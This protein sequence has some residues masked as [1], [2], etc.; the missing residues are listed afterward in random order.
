MAE[1]V[2]LKNGRIVR[3]SN[4]T[5]GTLKFFNTGYLKSFEYQGNIYHATEGKES[6]KY[7]GYRVLNQVLRFYAD[8]GVS[9][10]EFNR[11]RFLDADFIDAIPQQK[12]NNGSIITEGDT[13]IY[14]RRKLGLAFDK[15]ICFGLF[16]APYIV[17][18]VL[19]FFGEKPIAI[20]D[21]VADQAL[22][23]DRIPSN[24]VAYKFYSDFFGIPENRVP[25]ELRADIAQYI[26]NI[27]TYIYKEFL[28]GYNNEPSVWEVITLI[29]LF[30]NY[31]KDFENYDAYIKSANRE[32]LNNLYNELKKYYNSF[33]IKLIQIKE[34]SILSKRISLAMGMP[35]NALIPVTVEEK[36]E[37]LD[38]LV[39]NNFL[40]EIFLREEAEQLV[41]KVIRSFDNPVSNDIN[42]FL[43]QLISKKYLDGQKQITLFERLYESMSTNW[44]ITELGKNIS[45]R[46]FDTDWQVDNTKGAL[47]KYLYQLWI[48][49]Q[50]NPYDYLTGAFK[51]D[52]IG[53]IRRDTNDQIAYELEGIEHVDANGQI[54]T[55]ATPDPSKQFYYT[56]YVAYDPEIVYHPKA[57]NIE[58]AFVDIGNSLKK[59]AA[60]IRICYKS[61]K[62][63]FGV[64]RDNHD[65]NFDGEHIK[66]YQDKHLK[67]ANGAERKEA[68]V[69]YGTYKIYQ[70]ISLFDTDQETKIPI[71]T[72]D[73][74][75]VNIGGGNINS[76]IP[77]FM[78]KYIDDAGDRDD[79]QTVLGIIIEGLLAVTVVGNATKLYHLRHLSKIHYASSV[80]G[81]VDATVTTMSFLLNFVDQND[82][83]NNDFCKN[84]RGLLFWLEMATLSADGIASVV[85]SRQAQRVAQAAGVVETDD[86]DAAT[87]KVRQALGGSDQAQD[88]AY[89]ILQFANKASGAEIIAEYASRVRELTKK[90]MTDSNE[91]LRKKSFDLDHYSI[92]DISQ[93]VEHTQQY[94]V[95]LGNTFVNKNSDFVRV[96]SLIGNEDVSKLI[97][98]GELKKQ[99]SFY[100]LEVLKRG[101][102]SGFLNLIQYKK[103]C[104]EARDFLSERIS[105]LIDEYDFE[106]AFIDFD[107]KNDVTY[108]I[109]GSANRKYKQGDPI[110][111]NTPI[112]DSGNP[113]DLEFA[114]KMKPHDFDNFMQIIIEKLRSEG[115]TRLAGRAQ[116]FQKK[117]FAKYNDL[118]KILDKDIL[119]DLRDVIANNSTTFKND[120][121]DFAIVKEGGYYDLGPELPFNY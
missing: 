59:E 25:L 47:C 62:E 102:P 38:Y 8:I 82:C 26:H 1:A 112:P 24:S 90:L 71:Q 50:Y 40:S 106:G 34:S 84:L 21:S 39:T 61:Q 83:D 87:Q 19:D 60:P 2:I 27:D 42:I 17:E 11:S 121:I 117:G 116:Y 29:A 81:I 76:L 110:D 37:I 70:P 6:G 96:G 55:S 49:S 101:F 18:N 92:E 111:P 118:E 77:V 30:G 86:I 114:M 48:V 79:I 5:P 120:E 108:I 10:Q 69:L 54:Q 93:I 4:M 100:Y 89:L 13:I 74:A 66:A 23:C 56:R 104:N 68:P 31:S 15:S 98:L 14:E 119:E 52:A 43:E 46:A 45:N 35:F 73:G 44:K 7:A 103:F 63:L 51:N 80:I 85:A 28:G 57:T 99:I 33:R 22:D 109:Q 88:P 72:V 94:T 20:K 41:I 91:N 115:R 32:I 3:I 9:K 64:Y 53:F 95:V 75:P 67:I 65:F 58:Q 12:D 113:N 78:L 36:I 16:K 97:S 105:N 107:W